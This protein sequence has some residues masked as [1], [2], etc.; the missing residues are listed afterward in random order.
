MKSIFQNYRPTFFF[1]ADL[2][3]YPEIFGQDGG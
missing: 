2:S 1:V 3:Q